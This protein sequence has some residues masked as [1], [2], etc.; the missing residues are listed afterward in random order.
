MGSTYGATLGWIPYNPALRVRDRQFLRPRPQ[1]VGI[2]VKR[3]ETGPGIR[4]GHVIG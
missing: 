3:W 2:D 4:Y 1:N